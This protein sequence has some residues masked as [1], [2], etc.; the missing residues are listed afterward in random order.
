[1]QT[2]E[3]V[4]EPHGGEVRPN[5]CFLDVDYGEWSGKNLG[6]IHRS[7]PREFDTWAG[8]PEKAVFPG[9]EAVREVRERLREG[10][11]GLVRE[12]TGVVLL[13]GHN[14]VPQQEYGE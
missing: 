14:L 9:G 4:A 2:A 6:E 11:E 12:H 3:A 8:D 7:W 10:L 1:M 13:V 5:P